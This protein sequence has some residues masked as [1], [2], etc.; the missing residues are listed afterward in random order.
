MRS[1]VIQAA[2]A[3]RS[4]RRMGQSAPIVERWNGR[5]WRM[6]PSAGAGFT[7]SSGYL[8][9]VS[10]PT[11]GTCVASGES[12]PDCAEPLVE[13]GVR[14][15]WSQQHAAAPRGCLGNAEL[16][17]IFCR[18][19]SVCTAV[20][21]LANNVVA[22][23]QPLA[24]QE[25]ARRWRLL[26][27][28]VLSLFVDP[29]GGE[30]HLAGI[31]CPSKTTCLAV[32]SAGSELRDVPILERWQRGIWT[33]QRVDAHI[34]EGFLTS[35]SCTSSTRCTAVGSDDSPAGNADFP[36]VERLQ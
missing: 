21:L 11:A 9:A 3:S 6:E 5:S 20:G 2:I 16:S 31:S 33:A 25:V 15:H 8:T 24:E 26:T 4:A 10:C 17:G 32:G 12:E 27:P 7:S 23:V 13:R 36:L 1:R 29:W 14:G 19:P 35:I 22:Y 28:P 18:S 30:A 34:L